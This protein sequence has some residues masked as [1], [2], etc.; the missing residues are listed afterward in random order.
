MTKPTTLNPSITQLLD[1]FFDA[2][3][4][5]AGTALRKRI[6]LVR[7]HLSRQLEAEGPRELTTSQL[8]ILEADRQFDPNDAFARTMN[9]PEL[10]YVLTRYPLPQFAMAGWL[11]RQAQLDVI[12]A[13]ASYLWARRLVSPANVSECDLIEFDIAMERA[14]S[15]ARVGRGM[16]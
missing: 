14:R 2:Y 4:P 3:K 8:A 11:Q 15:A 10:Y 16:N 12:A 6:S 1:E 13:L 7:A 5:T 9:G